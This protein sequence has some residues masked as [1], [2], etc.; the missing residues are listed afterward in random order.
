MSQT[1]SDKLKPS[2][3]S[4]VMPTNV[5]S[6]SHKLGIYRYGKV[7]V[8]FCS[9]L[10]WLIL[11]E[12]STAFVWL[13]VKHAEK[14]F[15]LFSL[16]FKRCCLYRCY[17]R[18]LITQY[19]SLRCSLLNNPIDRKCDNYCLP[20]AHCVLI[21]SKLIQLSPWSDAN[22]RDAHLLRSENAT[23]A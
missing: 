13:S 6:N 14:L 22:R 16:T 8:K 23:V 10:E 15:A 12:N 19:Y 11:T 4:N 2:F 20:A 9:L 17:F 1:Q 7:R 5:Q 3:N 21:K 18:V